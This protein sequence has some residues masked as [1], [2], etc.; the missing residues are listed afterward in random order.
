MPLLPALL[1]ALLFLPL[2]SIA[3]TNQGVV[4]SFYRAPLDVLP[5]SPP[6][7]PHL[8]PAGRLWTVAWQDDAQGYTLSSSSPSISPE[9]RLLAHGTL[10]DASVDV[11]GWWQLAIS[12]TDLVGAE[13]K[14]GNL[15]RNNDK[16]AM[17]P[18]VFGEENDDDEE[19]AWMLRRWYAAGLLEGYLTAPLIAEYAYNAKHS[20]FGA[21]HY[22]R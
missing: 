19:A 4:E 8:P 5:S 21:H 2:S 9:K 13:Y 3:E 10:L 20:L 6:L 11:S 12:T 18:R 7:P 22:P 15:G 17:P 14:N 1:V 16:T